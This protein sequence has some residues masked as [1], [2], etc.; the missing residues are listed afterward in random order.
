M[1]NLLHLLAILT[2][3]ACLYVLRREAS[4][5]S[6]SRG[7]LLLAPP[8]AFACTMLM[9]GLTEPNL[10]QPYILRG[11]IAVGLVLGAI[12]GWLMAIDI[13]PLWS[14]VRLPDG[15]DGLAIGIFLAT[16]LVLTTIAPLVS[17]RSIAY[18]PYGT[19]TV[20]LGAGFLCA[21]AITVYLRSR[22]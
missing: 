13:D 14:T 17:S 9:I 1:L 12:R 16:V 4:G 6:Q 2:I 5:V 11:A 21:R 10:Q 3:A 8:L 19:A 15:R 7:H 18:V 20:A 22:G